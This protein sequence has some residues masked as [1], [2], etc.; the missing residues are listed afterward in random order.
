[1][2]GRFFR[3][4]YSQEDWAN[5]T[6][7]AEAAAFATILP[8][9]PPPFLADVPAYPKRGARNLGA[10][11]AWLN[12]VRLRPQLLDLLPPQPIRLNPFRRRHR[13]WPPRIDWRLGFAFLGT[14]FALL[15]LHRTVRAEHVLH[16]LAHLAAW[17]SIPAHG[18]RFRFCMMAIVEDLFGPAWSTRLAGAYQNRRPK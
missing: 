11:E 2:L 7:D 14:D 18:P 16:E 8:W 9:H 13:I 5:A 17:G 12:A 1:M 15:G 6:Y 10:L 4:N 3:G